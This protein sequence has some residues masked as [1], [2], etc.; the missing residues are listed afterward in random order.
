MRWECPFNGKTSLKSTR[1]EREKTPAGH[2]KYRE[3]P[4][5]GEARVRIATGAF[6]GYGLLAR[7]QPEQERRRALAPEGIASAQLGRMPTSKID[8]PG[9]GC[10]RNIL[11]TSATCARRMQN[12]IKMRVQRTDHK[13]PKSPHRLAPALALFNADRIFYL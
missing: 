5:V 11:V 13:C 10:S 4:R 6:E 1:S 3:C 2:F 9:F 12:A 8:Q 7:R